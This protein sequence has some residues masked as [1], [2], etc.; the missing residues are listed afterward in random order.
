MMVPVPAT[1]PL[2]LAGLVLL[3]LRRKKS[4]ESLLATGRIQ[5]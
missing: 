3:G 5:A 2:L 4:T 1:L